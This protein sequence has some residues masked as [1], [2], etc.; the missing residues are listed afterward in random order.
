MPPPFASMAL[1]A[2]RLAVEPP[3]ANEGGFGWG[4]AWSLVGACDDLV[5]RAAPAATCAARAGAGPCSCRGAQ[6]AALRISVPACDA[7]GAWRGRPRPSTRAAWG[8]DCGLCARLRRLRR[9]AGALAA[10][11]QRRVRRAVQLFLAWVG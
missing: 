11:T 8:G 9:V 10:F 1:P 6:G 7:C 3:S 5:T 2:R 4:F